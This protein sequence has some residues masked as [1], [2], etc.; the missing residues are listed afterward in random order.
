VETVAVYQ[1]FINAMDITT[2]VIIKMKLD[3]LKPNKQIILL[4]LEVYW[5]LW[6]LSCFCAIVVGVVAANQRKG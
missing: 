2:V 1:A 6:S 3:A 4:L 5:E